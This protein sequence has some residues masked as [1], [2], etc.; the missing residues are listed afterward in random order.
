MLKVN[1]GL[2]AEKRGKEFC[3]SLL[4]AGMNWFDARGECEFLL[5]ADHSFTLRLTPV[6]GKK[7]REVVVTLSGMPDRPPFA[8]RIFLSASCPDAKTVKLR[9]EDRGFGEFYP[10]SGLV[11]E[12]SL[13]LTETLRE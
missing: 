2:Q 9:I 8:T 7:M 4:D 3:L 11:W 5:D 12:E 13:S 10:S 6:S 1:L